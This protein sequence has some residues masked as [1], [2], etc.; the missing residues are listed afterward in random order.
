MLQ[1]NVKD[2]AMAGDLSN[3]DISNIP[4]RI[5][6]TMVIRILSGLEKRV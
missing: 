5:F 6:K 2:K 1:M 3:T 4:D